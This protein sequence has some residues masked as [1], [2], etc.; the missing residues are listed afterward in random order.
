MYFV[1]GYDGSPPANRALEAAGG[2]TQH[3]GSGRAGI[4]AEFT[5][6]ITGLQIPVPGA[7]VLP[8]YAW[9]HG[10]CVT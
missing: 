8:A 2:T 4:A 3:P 6:V 7:I 10:T 9:L 1:V 5:A